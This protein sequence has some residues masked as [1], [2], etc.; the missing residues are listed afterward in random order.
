MQWYRNPSAIL[1][2][3][4]ESRPDREEPEDVIHLLSSTSTQVWSP[5][6][7]Y[8]F[9]RAAD[10]HVTVGC[11]LIILTVNVKTYNTGP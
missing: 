4:R 2:Q 11:R 1:F 3:C 8:T 5:F 6:I 9:V 7:T 10:R